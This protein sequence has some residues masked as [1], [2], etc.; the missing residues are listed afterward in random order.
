M[1]HAKPQ[2][3]KEKGKR[4]FLPLFAPLRLC[5]RISAFASLLHVQIPHVQRVVFDELAARLDFVAHEPHEHFLGLNRIGEFD[6][7]QL[8]AVGGQGC[9]LCL[10][11]RDL[12]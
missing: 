9:D 10:G 2:S 12:A 5:V 11:G 4:C 1:S 3:R 8:A 7:Q 6:A